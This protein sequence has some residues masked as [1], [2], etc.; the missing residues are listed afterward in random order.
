VDFVVRVSSCNAHR[1][2][3][4]MIAGTST[5]RM[6]TNTSLSHKAPG[7][8]RRRIIPVMGGVCIL[9]LLLF[10]LAFIPSAAHPRQ[11]FDLRIGRLVLLSTQVRN[12]EYEHLLFMAAGSG[13]PNWNS[14]IGNWNFALVIR[15]LSGKG[16][17][18]RPAK[19][20]AD[21]HCT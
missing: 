9:F 1:Y 4:A 15:P 17:G 2:L 7:G 12:P 11:V 13:Y 16:S 18:P 6:T 14:S 8:S 21:G 20:L 3:E 5:P 19:R 10:A